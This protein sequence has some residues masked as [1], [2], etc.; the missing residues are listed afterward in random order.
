ML[1]M[2]RTLTA[3]AVLTAIAASAMHMQARTMGRALAE[4]ELRL[5]RAEAMTIAGG[6]LSRAATE[7]QSGGVAGGARDV[8]TRHGRLRVETATE[9]QTAYRHVVRVSVADTTGRV[10]GSYETVVEVEH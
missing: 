4:Q 5:A 6:E 7:V 8:D 2:R 3:I 1:P 10:L 9:R